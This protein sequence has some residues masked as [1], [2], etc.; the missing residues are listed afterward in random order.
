VND[1]ASIPKMKNSD[2]VRLGF[3]NVDGIPATVTNNSKVNAFR[4]YA[5]KHNLDGFFRAETNINWKKMFSRSCSVQRMQ[6]V[7][8]LLLINLRIGEGDSKVILSAWLLANWH[9]RFEMLEVMT[10]VDGLGCF[11]RSMLG[12]RCG[13]LQHINP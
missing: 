6:Y 9:Q 11:F 8:F 2:I 5:Y 12:T 10:S 3:K 13:S 7:W 1:V 4:R